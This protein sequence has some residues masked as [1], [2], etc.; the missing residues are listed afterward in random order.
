[1]FLNILTLPIRLSA[2]PFISDE[3]GSTRWNCVKSRLAD[4]DNV[5]LSCPDMLPST[6]KIIN[7]ISEPIKLNTYI[8]LFVNLT[9]ILLTQ[10]RQV[11]R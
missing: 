2:K 4:V 3:R 10:Q 1:M 5:I 9:I 8:F 11:M 7:S 6:K